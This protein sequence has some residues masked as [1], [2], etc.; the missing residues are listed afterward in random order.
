MEEG[1]NHTAM[2]AP[3]IE[4][5]LKEA[6]LAPADL[7]A[8][9]VSSGPGS[10]TGLRV[11]SS[12]VKAM[13]YSLGRPILAVDTLK[14]LAKAAF[15]RHPESE[16]ALPMIDARRK[17]V[18]AALFDRTLNEIWPVSSVILDERFFLEGLPLGGKIIAC[19]DGSAKIGDLALLAPHLSV[20]PAIRCSAGHLVPL[21]MDLFDTE[22]FQ[23]PLHFV[24]YYHKPPNIT[25]PKRAGMQGL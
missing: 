3:A 6:D 7:H 19:G 25:E 16:Y 22:K 9:A 21:A 5:I 24:P 23:D 13:A 8:I 11:G 1:M 12:T 20:D 14:A 10:Y 18:Y 17:E 4:A 2:L 15:D